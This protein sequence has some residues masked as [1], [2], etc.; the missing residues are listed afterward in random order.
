[1]KVVILQSNY[2][3]WR[4]YFDLINDADI[5]CFYD[6]VKYTKND[7]RNRNKIYTKNGLQWLTIPISKASTKLKI[8]EVL[9][10]KSWEE[11]HS[12]ILKLAYGRSLYYNQLKD[13]INEVY[14]NNK[15]QYLSDFNQNSIKYICSLLNIKTKFVTSSD[16][17]LKG[18]RVERLINLIKDIGADEYISGPSAS[19]YL[20]DSEYLF[21]ENNIKLTYK[22]Y[23]NYPI[24]NQLTEPFEPFVSILD[25][26]ANVP[27]NEIQNIFK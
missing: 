8:S 17:D 6:E 15:F 4:G 16:F 2:M 3:P 11:E 10:Q 12:Q 20:K 26:I 13:F 14:V 1:M 18:D 7:W 24:Y 22:N 23:N 5:F 27:L 19:V 25:V 21:A 9:F